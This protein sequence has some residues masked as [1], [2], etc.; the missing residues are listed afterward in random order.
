M[1]VSVSD[2]DASSPLMCSPYSE[3]VLGDGGGWP[4]AKSHLHILGMYFRVG[5]GP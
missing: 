5:G 2:D 4:A 3:V 1:F